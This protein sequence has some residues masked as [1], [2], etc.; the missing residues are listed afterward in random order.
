[1]ALRRGES[2]LALAGGVSVAASPSLYVDFARQRG[3]AADGRS[4]AFAAAAD[5]VVWSEGVGVLVLERLSDAQRLGHQVLAVVRG[6]AINQD[7]A[8]NGLTA[9]NGPSQQRVIAAA[10]AD[11]GLGP[12]DV[13]VVEAHG[14]GTRL[15]DPIEAQAVIAAYGADRDRDR[16]LFMGSVKSNIGHAVAAAGVG[17]VIKMVAALRHETLPKTLHVDVPTPYVDWSSGVVRLLT[18][19]RSWPVGERPRRAGVSS[20]G[21]SGTNAHVILEEAPRQTNSTRT[22]Q[23]DR[24]GGNSARARTVAFE[25]GAS[26]APVPLLIS[27]K[28]DAALRA[29]ADR[30]RQWLIDR[31][32]LDVVDIAY[33]LIET[34]AHLDRRGAVI[35]AGREELVAGLTEL[36]S[37]DTA[38][39]VIEGQVIAGKTAFLFTGQGA[40]RVGMG[41]ELS[42]AFPAFATALDEICAHM[43]P[44]LG[45][46]LR[47]VMFT[48][49]DGVLDRTEWTQPALFAFEVAMF[50]LLESFGVAPDLLIG[51]SI[52]EV[53]AA[54]VA[55]VWSLA[56]AC[57]LVA[58]RG[59]LMG[60]LPAG[61]AMVAVAMPEAEASQLATGYGDR[62]S[63]AAVNGPSSTVL[64]GDTD[65]IDEIETVATGRGVKTNRLRVSH[66]FHSALMDPVLDE[67]RAVAESLTYREPSLPLVSNVSGEL[68]GDAA[69]DPGYWV[70]QLRE[71]VRYATE[72]DTAVTE[73][74]CHFIEVG[75]DA[76][77]AAMTRQC[78]AEDPEVEDHTTVIA[79]SRRRVG[80]REV[81]GRAGKTEAEWLITALAQVHVAGMRVDW[82]PVFAGRPVRRVPLPTYAFQRRRFWLQPDDVAASMSDHPILTDVV[83][84]ADTDEWLFTGRFS[85]RTHPWIADH[86]AH[87]VVVVPGVLL[88]EFLLAAG[89]RIGCEAV[90]EVMLHA[91]ITPGDDEIELQ[92]LV[93]AADESGRRRFEFYYRK[94]PGG[95]WSRNA[96]GVLAARP[97]HDTALLSQLRDEEWP[98]ADADLLAVDG[99]TL[100]GQITEDTG[101]EYG[102]AFIGVQAVWERGD[103]V[104]SEVAL[105]TAAAPDPGRYEVHPALME[106]VVHAGLSRL[107]FR[108]G[109]SDPDTGWLLFR[110]GG[111]RFHRP[112]DDGRRPAGVTSLRVVAV[113]TGAESVAVAAV[114]GGGRPVLSVDAVVMRRYDVEEFRRG[115][116][117]EGAGLYRVGWEPVA[118]VS[119]DRHV[120]V[121]AVLGEVGVSGVEVA[122][123]SVAEVVAAEEVPGALIWRPTGSVAEGPGA[124]RERVH[125]TLTVLKSWLAEERLSEVR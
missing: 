123:G 51:H 91:P 122:Y 4:K 32:D 41:R 1:Q 56:D 109:G 80:D 14:T 79:V 11:A 82:S 125:A 47:E 64:S 20:F 2:S 26:S 6:S 57:A 54:Y 58:A 78:L 75:P 115:L 74:V 93:Q 50:R 72:V 87:G 67:F 42:A 83:G 120:P 69:T 59:R 34:R 77:L 53:A 60:A 101:L 61:G 90:E 84:L 63:V 111:A 39:S 22:S 8:S 66:A 23:V 118:A 116:S 7:G 36:A 95:E 46:S 71:C 105:D 119:D 12:A 49:P 33:S 106:L 5:G 15:G 68:A 13:D 48:D 18:E 103:A 108:P 45:R 70:R 121:L 92:A 94:S 104:F 24:S 28:S 55:G 9:P 85:L 99:A 98:P 27:A 40:Q 19:P 117:V 44:L 38:P 86:R 3:L 37:G 107:V 76:V 89:G 30:L 16:P 113:R 17:G 25:P 62:V 81:N 102:P 97:E 124:V 10:L 112:M 31:P 100:A 73:G 52:G 29:Q 88:L 110:W 65:A 21:I 114:D 43:D 35:G 96:T